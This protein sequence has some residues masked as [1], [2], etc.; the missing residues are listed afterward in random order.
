MGIFK[1]GGFMKEQDLLESFSGI[2]E[3]LLK[4]SENNKKTGS[5]ETKAAEKSNA[6]AGSSWRK[7]GYIAAVLV[8]TAGLI[9]LFIH[10]SNKN[11]SDVSDIQ[12]QKIANKESEKVAEDG[13]GSE[14]LKTYIVSAAEYPT[15]L[16]KPDFHDFDLNGDNTWDGDENK[17]YFEAYQEWGKQV[18]EQKNIEGYDPDAGKNGILSFNSKAIGQFLKENN[19]ENRVYSPINIYIALGM[20]AET[21]DGNTR[22]Q[23]LDLL[24]IETIEA[25]RVQMKGLWNSVYSDD[26]TKS[27]LA[28]SIWLRDDLD[29]NKE[30]MDSLA[31]NYYN[32][33]FSGKMGSEEYSEV[34]R[35]WLN[36]QTDGILKEQISGLELN[37]DA[38]MSLATTVCFS[39]KWLDEFNKND[40]TLDT[41]H[42]ASGD[43]KCDFM[44]RSTQGAYYWGDKFGAIV[45]W[46]D[47]AMGYMSYILPDEGVSVYDLLQDEQVMNFVN[48]GLEYGQSKRVIINMSIPKF[49]VSSNQDIIENLKNLGITDAFDMT[50]AD[51]SPIYGSDEDISDRNIYINK[52]GHGVRVIEDEEGVKAAAYTVEDYAT[53][54]EP[55]EEKVDF[56]LDR[57]FMFVINYGGIPMFVGI[58]EKP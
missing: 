18:A 39:A 7:L 17:A 50:K 53:A 57:P 3:E 1:N 16:K 20:M 51:F 8:I 42:T 21:S 2:S 56:V 40:T 19:H 10:I 35:S 30:T 9:I 23:I 34:Y 47:G 43:I 13:T 28:S 6:K 49:D 58:V 36:D 37:Q 5:N 31:R 54:T 52:V 24:G 29:Y 55:P 25:L 27:I 15:A 48:Q 22:K 12:G 38:V 33:S 45:N 14:F 4:R 46:F 26:K 44:H 41:F 11:D 32:S